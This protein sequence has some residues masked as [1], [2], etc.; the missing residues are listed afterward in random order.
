LQKV[1]RPPVS[2]DE[3]DAARTPMRL[4]HAGITTL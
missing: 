3:A 2:Q 4:I 1:F